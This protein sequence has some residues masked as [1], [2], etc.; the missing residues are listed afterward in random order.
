MTNNGYGISSWGDKNVLELDC[1]DGCTTCEY[2]EVYT[3]NGGIICAS[4]LNKAIKKKRK[5]KHKTNKWRK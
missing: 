2:T 4:Y 1:G 5:T 3:L